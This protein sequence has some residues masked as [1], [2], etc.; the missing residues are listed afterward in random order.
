METTTAYTLGVLTVIAI[1]VVVVLIAGIVKVLKQQ[2]EIIYV[3]A[4]ITE[5]QGKIDKNEIDFYQR[6]H[7]I[8]QELNGRVDESFQHTNSR[9]GEL[10]EKQAQRTPKQLLKG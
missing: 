7:D 2:K 8:R 9:I 1:T 10:Q 4:E 3:Y 6:T 5:L